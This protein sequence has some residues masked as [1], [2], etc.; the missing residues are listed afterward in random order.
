[1]EA[2]ELGKLPLIHDQT[3]QFD[4]S[5]PD[6]RAWFAANGV[7][8]VDAGRGLHFNSSVLAVQAAIEGH[9]VA[10][11]RSLVVDGDLRARRLVR[12]CA[13]ELPVRCAY[14]VLCL[15]DGRDAPAVRAVHDWLFAEMGASQPTAARKEN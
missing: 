2:A 3:I 8:H 13:G 7:E 11:G 10:L 6:W 9:G 14:Y 15:P 1:M 4:A 12:P 5:F